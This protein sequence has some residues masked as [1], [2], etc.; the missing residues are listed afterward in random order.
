MVSKVKDTRINIRI[1]TAEKEAWE[2]IADQYGLTLTEFV[3][4]SVRGT[5]L[6]LRAASVGSA[7]NSGLGATPAVNFAFWPQTQGG[8]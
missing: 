4:R 7:P 3:T 6:N 5:M 2:Q 1:P 8:S